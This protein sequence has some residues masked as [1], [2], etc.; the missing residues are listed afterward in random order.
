MPGASNQG[1]QR[2]PTTQWSIVIAAQSERVDA[3]QALERLCETYWYPVYAFIRSRTRQAADAEDLTQGFFTSLLALRSV[4]SA[5]PE[6][7]RFRAFLLGAAKHFLS[8]EWARSGAQKRGSG[9]APLSLDFAD[10]ERRYCL[11]PVSNANPELQYEREWA[12]ATFQ[13][14]LE[15]LREEFVADGSAVEFEAYRAYL[16][17]A[18]DP[19]SYAETARGL[20]TTEAAVRIGVHRI[21]RRVGRL[22]RAQVANTV[23]GDSDGPEWE[24]AVDEEM[25][26]LL[27]L[28]R[29]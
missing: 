12:R 7:G 4:D 22:L 25:E 8:T 27:G 24:L 11:E 1:V 19:P 5:R 26:Y 20:E 21:R 16:T 10:G 3:R 2:F 23:A 13:A 6:R 28:L 15:K 9:R 18:E 14:A 29:C 17:A